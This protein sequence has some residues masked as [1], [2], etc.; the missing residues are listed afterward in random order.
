MCLI[1]KMTEPIIAEKDITCYKVIRKDMSSLLHPE[2]EWDFGWIYTSPIKVFERTD[3]THAIYQALHS[4]KTLEDLKRAYYMA[5]VSCLAVECIIPKGTAF[6]KGRHSDLEGYASSKLMIDEVIDA[7]ELYPDFDWDNYPYKE[8]QIVQIVINNSK[9]DY[10]IMNIQPHPEDNTRVDLIVK[11]C[12]VLNFEHTIKTTFDG[13]VWLSKNC[14]ILS[15]SKE[16]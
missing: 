11:N 7:K 9:G 13:K 8:G 15:K 2:F 4:Y 14:V 12:S 6:Y 16:E 1:T 3:N 10:Q 5:T